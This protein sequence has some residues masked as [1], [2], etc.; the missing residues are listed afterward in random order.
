MTKL[1]TTTSRTLRPYDGADGETG[2][3]GGSVWQLMWQVHTESHLKSTRKELNLSEPF[4]H[5]QHTNSLHAEKEYLFLTDLPSAAGR[6]GRQRLFCFGPGVL[7]YSYHL[8]PGARAC[9]L[10]VNHTGNTCVLEKSVLMLLKISSFIAKCQLT[11]NWVLPII[12]CDQLSS[13]NGSTPAMTK[14]ARKRLMTFCV[15]RSWSPSK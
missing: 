8:A 4:V 13:S 1:Q 5:L 12:K 15:S 6:Q 7:I 2:G 10:Q 9:N 14:L 11:T 3:H